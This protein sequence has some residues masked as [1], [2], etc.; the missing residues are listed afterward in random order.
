MKEDRTQDQLLIVEPHFT[1]ELHS[2]DSISCSDAEEP[3]ASQI[4]AKDQKLLDKCQLKFELGIPPHMIALP[5]IHYI[6]ETA[7]RLLFKTI[8]WIKTIPSFSL[9]K[10]SLQEELI[11][12]AWSS[13]FI[14]GLAQI[15]G[16]VFIPS[17]L[18]LVVSHQQARL[19]RDPGV[20][21]KDVVEMVCKIHQYVNTLV[22]MELDDMEFAYLRIIVLSD[23]YH[24]SLE[25]CQLQEAALSQLQEYLIGQGRE[26]TR[27][28]RLLLLLSVP[29]SLQPMAVEDLFFA[30]KK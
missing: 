23:N 21:V 12:R 19:S 22:R 13:L 20:N 2:E 16:Q 6:S 15:S 10:P 8:H 28:P 7:S 3:I 5:S 11:Q 1:Q 29:R 25:V 24:Q 4:L 27:F 17:L 26:R 30:G 14:L 9:L 18:S